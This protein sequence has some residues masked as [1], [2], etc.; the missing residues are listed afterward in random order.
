MS[1]RRKAFTERINVFFTREQLENIKFR[2][3]EMGISVSAY[4]RFAVLKEIGIFATTNK[5]A[6][7]Q[8]IPELELLIET[9]KSTDDKDEKAILL[10]SYVQQKG[11]IPDVY[12]DRIMAALN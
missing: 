2:A 11:S 6:T 7:Q 3:E 12:G 5:E 9:L 1:P 10:E 8:K 4:V